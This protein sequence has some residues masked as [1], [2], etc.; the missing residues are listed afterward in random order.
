MADEKECKLVLTLLEEGGNIE[1]RNLGNVRA[2]KDHY[3]LFST[4]K[5]GLI[6]GYGYLKGMI[7]NAINLIS[8]ESARDSVDRVP[9]R[10][11]ITYPLILPGE[12]E[13]P[14]QTTASAL[15][16]EPKTDGNDDFTDDI[17]F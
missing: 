17:P 15:T 4:S 13:K 16:S 12:K 2:V 1:V 9:T 6:I 14:F 3:Y 5:D 11:E 8:E 7:H 10:I